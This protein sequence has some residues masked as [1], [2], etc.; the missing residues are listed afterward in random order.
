MI[1]L[2]KLT[3]NP[4]DRNAQWDLGRPYRLHQTLLKSFGTDRQ[5]SNVLHRIERD[6]FTH[7]TLLVQATEAADWSR[8]DPAYLV[9]SE[10]KQIDFTLPAGRTLRFRLR[11]CPSK[12]MRRIDPATGKRHN[13][14]RNSRRAFLYKAD[15]QLDWLARQGE[16]YGFTLGRTLITQPRQTT[17][18][19]IKLYSVLFEGVLMITDETA[20]NS[21]WQ[22]GIGAS[23]AFGCGLLSLRSA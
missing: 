14:D 1:Y 2:T 9:N 12:R 10:T 15:D 5:T 11:A 22:K 3:L 16:K 8:L 4:A 21:A 18:R 23:K 20:F 19:N 17:D 6:D 13:G 7:P